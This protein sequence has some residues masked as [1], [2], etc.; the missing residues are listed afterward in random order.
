[1]GDFAV[2]SS[3]LLREA[4][5]WLRMNYG[6]Y[7]FWV[8]RDLVWT[9]QTRLR[10]VVWER[11]LPYLV[12]SEYP[13]LAGTRR[14]VCAD[15]V[16]RERQTGT[17]V[18][19]EFKYEPRHERADFLAIPNKLP[20]VSW[21]ADGVAKDIA[22]I[23]TFVEAGVVSAGFAVFVDEGRRFRDRPVHPGSTWMDWDDAGPSI[24][25]SQW[26]GGLFGHLSSGAARNQAVGVKT[27]ATVR[28]RTVAAMTTIGPQ[29]NVGVQ[30]LVIALVAAMTVIAAAPAPATIPVALTTTVCQPVIVSNCRVVAPTRPSSRSALRRS[31]VAITSVLTRDR[32]AN[33]AIAMRIKLLA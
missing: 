33:A 2:A 25:W 27:A 23:R 7:E 12:L 20:G 26:P 4:L 24:L 30:V 5:D 29:L 15:L 14:S 6:R 1:M 32:P 8:E 9:V 22:R 17:M 3:Q 21:G 19:A 31:A 16:I 28:T 18:A 13:L 10:Q 11:E